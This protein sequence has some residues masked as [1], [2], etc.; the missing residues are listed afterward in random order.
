MSH[1]KLNGSLT[2]EGI[3]DNLTRPMG[4]SGLTEIETTLQCSSWPF[5]LYEK[6]YLAF[7]YV[8]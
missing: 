1:G 2:S 7:M 8:I 5:Q 3:T 4:A 6:Y